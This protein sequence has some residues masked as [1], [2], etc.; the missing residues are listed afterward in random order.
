MDP[1]L[2]VPAHPVALLEIG[3]RFELVH[4]GLV[5]RVR[6]QL[7]DLAGGEVGDADVPGQAGFEEGF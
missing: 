6:E 4:G 3:V 2:L 1:V 5:G 7:A